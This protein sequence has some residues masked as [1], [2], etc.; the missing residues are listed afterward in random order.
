MFFNLFTAAEPHTSVK[1]TYGTPCIDPWVQWR[2][3]TRSWSYIV[4]QTHFPSRAQPLWGWQA[5]KDDQYEIWP[6]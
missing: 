6:H 2:K 1:V 4:S 5:S 3:L